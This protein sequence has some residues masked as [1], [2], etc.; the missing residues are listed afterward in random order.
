MFEIPL[1]PKWM[2]IGAI[3]F[4][5]GCA[6]AY[7]YNLG[8]NRANL[9]CAAD[10]IRQQI[11]VTA[12]IQEKNKIGN[13]LAESNMQA[14]LKIQSLRDKNNAL[15]NQHANDILRYNKLNGMWV[16]YASGTANSNP[17]TTGAI[18]ATSESILY[19]SD[20][21][22]KQRILSESD[23]VLGAAHYDIDLLAHDHACTNQLNSLIEYNGK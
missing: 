15:I 10:N 1:L 8:E 16:S 20:L 12:V 17:S 23:I 18:N 6:V 13:M 9:R 7:V 3:V 5:I 14:N 21:S 11:A 4:G 19:T 2:G 22:G